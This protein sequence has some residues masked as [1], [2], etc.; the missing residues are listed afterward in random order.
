MGTE[1][2]KVTKRPE[3]IRVV[4]NVKGVDEEI[5]R[6]FKALCTKRGLSLKVGVEKVMREELQRAGE[7]PSSGSK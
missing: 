7:L 6:L 4:M 3:E 2:K 5:K 1:G